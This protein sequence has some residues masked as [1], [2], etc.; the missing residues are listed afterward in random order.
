M[1]YITHLA[2]LKNRYFIQR[3]G[4]SEANLLGII[5]SDPTEGV[6]KYGLTDEGRAQVRASA[7]QALAKGLLGAET[8]IISSDFKRAIET[9]RITQ[10][11]LGAGPVTLTDRLRERS[12]GLHEGKSNERYQLVWDDDAK[13]PTHTIESVESVESVLERATSIILEQEEVCEEKTFLLVSHGDTLQIL[14]TAFTSLGGAKHRSL[15]HLETA[16]IRELK[17]DRS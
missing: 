17:L 11:V 12:F 4:K 13:D 16:E 7:E 15:P 6:P 2:K 3:H 8:I 5:L 1:N 9:A 10:E 14:Q